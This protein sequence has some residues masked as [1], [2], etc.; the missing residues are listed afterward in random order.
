MA[1]TTS[2]QCPQVL[3][4]LVI[5]WIDAWPDA[6]MCFFDMCF[7]LTAGQVCL[8]WHDGDARI[9]GS[10]SVGATLIGPPSSVASFTRSTGEAS[11]AAASGG[12]A[13]W[14]Q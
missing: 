10:E 3:L 11:D 9:L 8:I 1:H 13:R 7:H 2:S 6:C 4:V 5:L 12:V 14:D